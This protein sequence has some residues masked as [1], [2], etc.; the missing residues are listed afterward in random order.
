MGILGDAFSK[1]FSVIWSG[2]KW[3]GTQIQNL[4]KKLL[5]VII[6]FFRF[7]YY[8]IDGFLYF[9]FSVG[10]VAVKV[11]LIFFELGKVLISIFVGFGKTLASF[12]YIQRSS[13]GNGY[14]DTIG[15]IMTAANDSLQLDVIAYILMFVIWFVWVVSAMKLLSSIRV[16]GD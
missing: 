5:E 2:L 1:L 14:S 16:G 13:S 7:I 11:F 10:V 15:R 6:S 8:M 3:L 4:F 9:L 12:T